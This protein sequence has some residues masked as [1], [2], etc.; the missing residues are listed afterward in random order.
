[1]IVHTPPGHAVCL[2]LRDPAADVQAAL[3]VPQPGRDRRFIVVDDADR[4]VA[5][6]REYEQLSSYGPA[7]IVCLAVGANGERTLRRSLTL[8]PTN[9]GVLWLLDPHGGG[10]RAGDPDAALRPLVDVLAPPDVFD[11]LLRALGGVVHGVAV[12]SVRLLEHDL[13]DEARARVWRQALERLAGPDAPAQGGGEPPPPA[14]A[15]LLDDSLPA[16]LAGHDWLP[17]GGRAG[18]RLRDC[19]AALAD[20]VADCEQIR[21]PAGLFTGVSRAPDLP[22]GLERLAEALTR[23]RNTVADAFTA[24]SGPRLTAEHRARIQEFGIALPELPP[25]VTRAG[26]VPGLRDHTEALVARPLPLRSVAARLAALSARSAPAGSAARLAR[27]DELCDP[28][29][30]RH[31]ARPVPFTAGGSRPVAAVVTG[32]L[33]YLAGLWP[34]LGWGLGPVA[35]L[36]A[37]GLAVLVLRRRPSRS[38]GGRLDGG[39]STGAAPRLFGGV[40]GGLAGAATGQFLGPPAW[41]G[42]AGLLVGVLTILLLAVRDWSR[43]VDDWWTR[44]DAEYAGRITRDVQALVAE[45]A[46]H[47]WLFAEVRHH[48]SD[49]S[50]TLAHLLRR[51]ART[52]DDHNRPWTTAPSAPTA[53]KPPGASDSWD[54]WTDWDDAADAWSD[55]SADAWDEPSGDTWSSPGTASDRTDGR[56]DGPPDG[57]TPPHPT[58]PHPRRPLHADTLPSWLERQLGDGGPALLD[59]LVDD[60]VQGTVLVLD[61]CW[62]GLER[63]PAGVTGDAFDAPMGQ[64]LDDTHER[65][66]RDAAASP[67]RYAADPHDRPDAARLTGVATDRVAR[68]VTAEDAEQTVP[69]CGPEHRR[70]LSQDPSAV[71][72]VAFVPEAMRRDAGRDEQRDGRLGAAEDVVWTPGGRHAGVVHLVPLRADVVRT[73]REEE[74]EAP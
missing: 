63:D 55:G 3:D 35:G 23:F 29:Y 37:A 58:V 62:A 64:L 72:R 57:P 21:G 74:S 13:T 52:A 51:L 73:V 46:V 36:L 38:P 18:A 66:L 15:P 30:L 9:A 8:R 43:G 11:A 56:I 20:V 70:L 27:L 69:L 50:G 6:Q 40:L 33:A 12:P 32:V 2:D 41:A 47:D 34:L 28:G 4:I 53:E 39:G 17:A 5:H 24:A 49:A 61:G 48:C 7:R 45:T 26:V 31:L 59:T 19:V 22:G 44:T 67:P 71:R 54:D 60:L 16:S 68:L 14:L 1:M 65:L 25:E 42:A 10:N